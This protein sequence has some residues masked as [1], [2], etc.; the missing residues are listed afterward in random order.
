MQLM[1]LTVRYRPVG[2]LGL[3]TDIKRLNYFQLHLFA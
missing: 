2:P 1:K 3:F